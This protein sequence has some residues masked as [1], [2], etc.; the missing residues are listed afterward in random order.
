MSLCQPYTKFKGVSNI[1]DDFLL[2]ILESNFKTFL[3]WAFLNIGSWFDASISSNNLYSSTNKHSILLLTNDQSYNTGQ[4]WQGIRKDWV[5]ETGVIFNETSPIS[6]SGIYVNNTFQPNDS[7]QYS[8]NYPDGQVIFNSAKSKSTKVELNYSYR[9]IQVY[10]SN[11]NPWFS[12]IQYSSFNTDNKDIQRTD[13]GNWSISGN[14][15]IQLPAIVIESVPRSRSRPFEIGND[16]LLI[17]QD[18]SFYVLA[19]NKNDRN[20]I[21]DILRLQQDATI[22]LYN[23]N[24]V[25]KDDNYPLDYNGDLKNNP[26]MY[27]QI[28]DQYKWR[29]CWIK[30]VSLYELDSIHTNFHQ[31]L[32]RATV[33]I[34]ST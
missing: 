31:G 19:E 6:I 14:H 10:R 18:I 23:T 2:N 4:V 11:D 9:N 7:T 16:N 33:E 32:A 20:K 34:I 22:W 13:D 25:A 26:L 15:R 17:E 27:P 28:I 29:K 1:S 5:W 3:D 30:D 21:L 8:I 24:S 12:T